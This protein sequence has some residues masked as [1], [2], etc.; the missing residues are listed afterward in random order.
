MTK[1][2]SADGATT[3]ANGPPLV[4]TLSPAGMPSR[5]A[6]SGDSDAMIS[7]RTGAGMT[8]Q[9]ARDE[10]GQPHVIQDHS[11]NEAVREVVQP[12]SAVVGHQ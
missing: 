8:A 1:S 6:M 5:N 10:R 7:A 2:G 12:S 9:A 4:S 11:R 3:L